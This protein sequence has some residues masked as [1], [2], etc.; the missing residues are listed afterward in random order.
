MSF[1]EKLD[2]LRGSVLNS[3]NNHKGRSHSKLTQMGTDDIMLLK[4][5]FVI[6][7]EILRDI[8][9]IFEQQSGKNNNKEGFSDMAKKLF[10]DFQQNKMLSKESVIEVLQAHIKQSMDLSDNPNKL[11]DFMKRRGELF[12]SIM[13]DKLQIFAQAEQQGCLQS[14]TSR[15][16]M[17]TIMKSM[18]HSDMKNV[19][20]ASA[21]LKMNLRN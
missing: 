13:N 6:L 8:K 20:V 2:K 17:Q 21:T 7:D 14:M 11:T 1:K 5:S 16:D 10:G 12:T 15:I 3:A 9:Q 19:E 18:S 4:N